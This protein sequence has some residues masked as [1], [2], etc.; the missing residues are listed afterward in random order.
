MTTFFAKCL[1]V[2][3]MENTRAKIVASHIVQRQSGVLQRHAICVNGFPI[4]IEDDDGLR[5]CIGHASK[6]FFISTELSF[7]A[8]QVLNVSIRSVPVDNVAR[9][10]AQWLRPKQEPSI[11][12]VEST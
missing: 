4:R 5:N 8:L 1:S 3:G 6:L 12:S 11:H 7:S 10:V 2:V 9:F